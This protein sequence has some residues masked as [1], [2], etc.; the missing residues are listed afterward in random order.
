MQPLAKSV[1]NASYALE[2][3]IRGLAYPHVYVNHLYEGAP[4]KFI[5]RGER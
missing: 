1:V 5:L 4:N 3:I 2:D